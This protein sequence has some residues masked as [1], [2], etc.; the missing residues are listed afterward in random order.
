MKWIGLVAGLA[1]A[2]LFIELFGL[3]GGLLAL[4]ALAG[5]LLGHLLG[6]IRALQKELTAL[7]RALMP[8]PEEELAEAPHLTH[9]VSVNEHPA[10]EEE[11]EGSDPDQPDTIPV[12]PHA[13]VIE[14][15]HHAA[16][17]TPSARLVAWFRRL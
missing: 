10:G 1:L 13:P 5:L 6:R 16:S 9:A 11:V 14:H 4:G 17:L 3:Q 8:T 2:A 7:R 12:L 15:A